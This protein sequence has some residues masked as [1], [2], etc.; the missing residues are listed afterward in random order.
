[1]DKEVQVWNRAR[2]Y[3]DARDDAMTIFELLHGTAG[4]N[5]PVIV[6]GE[7]YLAMAVEAAGSPA[8]IENPDE[9]GFFVF[10]TNYIW[11]LE[12]ASC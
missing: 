7:N 1:M 6:S 10:S 8:P 11:R 5:L 9:R 4:W 12:K 2:D 3:M